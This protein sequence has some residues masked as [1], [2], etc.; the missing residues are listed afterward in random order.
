MRSENVPEQ[1][2]QLLWHSA[3]TQLKGRGMFKFGSTK[4]EEQFQNIPQNLRT[5]MC[6]IPK[7]HMLESNLLTT[8]FRGR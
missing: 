2:P 8:I 3:V 1:M 5:E 7:I 4:P 6:P